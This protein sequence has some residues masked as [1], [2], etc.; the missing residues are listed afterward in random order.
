MNYTLIFLL[1]FSIV[2]KLFPPKKPNYLYGYQLGSAKK[3]IEHWKVA[4]KYAAN[5]MIKLYGIILTLSVLFD[6]Q[7][8]EGGIW[9]L[10]I[11]FFGVILIYMLIE[12]KLEKLNQS[13]SGNSSQAQ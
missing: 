9:I 6:S 11:L 3:S 7:N 13:T 4:N 8:Y 10:C 5:Y 1:A 12:K 2:L